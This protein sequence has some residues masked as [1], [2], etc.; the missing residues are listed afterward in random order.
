MCANKVEISISILRQFEKFKH[1]LRLIERK[2]KYKKELMVNRTSSFLVRLATQLHN[3][4]H[5]DGENSTKS[6]T[7]TSDREPPPWNGQ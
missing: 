2:W 5:L 7:K 6:D 4:Y 3:K 1:S